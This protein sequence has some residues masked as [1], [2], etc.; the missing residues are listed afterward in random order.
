MSIPV[1]AISKGFYDGDRKRPGD[2]FT[3]PDE[4]MLGIWMERLDGKP[5]PKAAQQR[6]LPAKPA[7][8]PAPSTLSEMNG[9]KAKEPP[10][11][12]TKDGKG[13]GSGDRKVI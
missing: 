4:K 3:V 13:E 10:K 6:A 1:R 8:A 5:H 9:V 12:D 11:G 7:A 2:T